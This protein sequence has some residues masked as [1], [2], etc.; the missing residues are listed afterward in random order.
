LRRRIGRE[1][2][3]YSR[4]NGIRLISRDYWM[5][6]KRRRLEKRRKCRE[7]SIEEWTEK[8]IRG[9]LKQRLKDSRLLRYSFSFSS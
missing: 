2:R 6:K 3:D 9:T 4:I 1:R 5:S 7:K 8:I